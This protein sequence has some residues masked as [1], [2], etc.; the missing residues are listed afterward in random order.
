[1]GALHKVS[2][3]DFVQV[4]VVVTR[5]LEIRGEDVSALHGPCRSAG[6]Q[7]GPAASGWAQGLG[8][9][10]YFSKKVGPL[11]CGLQQVK[12][13]GHAVRQ[14][15]CGKE[16]VHLRRRSTRNVRNGLFGRAH[17]ELWPDPCR[18]TRV[19]RRN[20]GLGLCKW[21]CR[22]FKS[23]SVV[24]S[25]SARLVLKESGLLKL[26]RRSRGL[27]HFIG[28]A[29]WASPCRSARVALRVARA[30]QVAVYA[31]SEGLELGLPSARLGVYG[32]SLASSARAGLWRRIQKPWVGPFR[33]GSGEAD[34]PWTKRE[35]EQEIFGE[36]PRGGVVAK[37]I[38]GV[39]FVVVQTR[40]NHD[41]LPLVGKIL[42]VRSQANMCV[43]KVRVPRQK[44][45]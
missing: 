36:I 23:S 35:G 14:G 1:M 33:V 3:W 11:L 24:E 30:Q 37:V 29:A 39:L 17:L 12:V 22:D 10:E 32:T 25:A 20:R 31:R 28:K 5:V 38:S 44:V 7:D 2:M 41:P 45:C 26:R 19:I 40:E 4:A 8:K 34:G 9:G 6:D 21:F 43:P 27:F 16:A 18:S 15:L 13:L 42:K